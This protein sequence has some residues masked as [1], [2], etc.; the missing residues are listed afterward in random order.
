MDNLKVPDLTI[1]A[2]M[3]RR[4]KTHLLLTYGPVRTL[5]FKYEVIWSC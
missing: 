3:Q 1:E 2:N 4:F 5:A